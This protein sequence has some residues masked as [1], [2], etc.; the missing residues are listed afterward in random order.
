[1][2]LT[3]MQL[4]NMQ[5]MDRKLFNTRPIDESRIGIFRIVLGGGILNEDNGFYV[6]SYC[7]RNQWFNGNIAHGK[8]NFYCN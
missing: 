3:N 5:L 1:M 2:Q 7:Q 4:T 8:F 6:I